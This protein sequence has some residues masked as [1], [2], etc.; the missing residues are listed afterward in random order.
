MDYYIPPQI[1][2]NTATIIGDMIDRKYTAD[3]IAFVFAVDKQKVND[4][5]YKIKEPLLLEAGEHDLQI[6]WGQGAFSYTTT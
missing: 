2:E 5:Y 6:W 1:M 4:G 3:T